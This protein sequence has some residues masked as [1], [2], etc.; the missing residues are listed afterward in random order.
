MKT[1][2]LIFCLCVLGLGASAIAADLKDP[3]RPPGASNA[4]KQRELRVALPRVTAILTSSRGRVAIFN[5]QPVQVG[6]K[7][8]AYRINDITA[9]GVVYSTLGKSAFAALESPGS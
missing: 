2:D 6:D 7:V 8:G 5:D 4:A 3:T 1:R 9:T